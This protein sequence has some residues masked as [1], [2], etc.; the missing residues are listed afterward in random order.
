MPSFTVL[1]SGLVVLVILVAV[2]RRAMTRFSSAKVRE[3]LT[4]SRAWM[5]EHQARKGDD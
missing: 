1:A 3:D 2:V 4:V 5:L